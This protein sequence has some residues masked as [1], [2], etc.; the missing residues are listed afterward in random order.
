M[1]IQISGHTFNLNNGLSIDEIYIRIEI[2]LNIKGDRI[3]IRN[4]AYSSKDYYISGN[5]LSLPVILSTNIPY[6][7]EIDGNDIL[8][9]AHEKIK[10]DLIDY[11]VSE[12]N[13]QIIDIIFG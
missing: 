8:K 5:K 4:S 7:R 1:A 6:N 10:Q 9:V 13:I 11:G 12:P 2:S 3:T